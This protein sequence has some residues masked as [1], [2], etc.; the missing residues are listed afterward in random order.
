M[1]FSVRSLHPQ[2][3]ISSKREIYRSNHTIF[4][5]TN[6]TNW[7]SRAQFGNSIEL[8]EER[9]LKKAAAMSTIGFIGLGNMGAHMARNLIKGGHKL[10]VHD[11]VPKAVEALKVSILA[12]GRV[13]D[14]F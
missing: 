12:F 9:S 5:R 1:I 11:A 8:G 13:D 4:L 14:L 6:A 10:V 2:P 3:S 7:F